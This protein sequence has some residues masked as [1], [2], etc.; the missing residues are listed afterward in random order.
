MPIYPA[1]FRVGQDGASREYP[2]RVDYT[3]TCFVDGVEQKTINAFAYF[4]NDNH[5]DE[6]IVGWNAR[7]EKPSK[8]GGRSYLYA[9]VTPRACETRRMRD[10]LASIVEH[11]GER[12]PNSGRM[13]PAAR[14]PTPISEAMA[15]L[16]MR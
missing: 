10:T 3:V 1:S 13:L 14:Q 15:L 12:A 11:F 2:H 16:G 8:V 5:A 7:G 6:R 9:R 4:I